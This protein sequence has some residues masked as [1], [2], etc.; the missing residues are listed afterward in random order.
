MTVRGPKRGEIWFID[1][2]FVYPDMD[3]PNPDRTIGEEITKERPVVVISS[4]AFQNQA[5]RIVIPFTSWQD[6]FADL[7][8]HYRVDA[9][10]V[11]RLSNDS[12][13]NVLQTRCISTLRFEGYV[14]RLAQEQLSEVLDLLGLIIEAE[15]S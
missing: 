11:N 3:T 1:P 8:F 6:H 14:G 13:L 10:G 2:D 9:D 5:V 7:D 12:S 4:D 15:F